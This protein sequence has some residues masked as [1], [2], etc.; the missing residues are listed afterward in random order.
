MIC[1]ALTSLR[2]TIHE[3]EFLHDKAEI[4]SFFEKLSS[5]QTFLE[6]ESSAMT[7]DLKTK[8]IDFALKAEDLQIQLS[9]F[10]QSKHTTSSQEKASK[11][12]LHQDLQEATEN[13]TELL[14]IITKGKEYHESAR[15]MASDTLTIFMKKFDYYFLQSNPVVFLDDEAAKIS[16]F[17]KLSSMQALLQEESSAGGAI[18]ND[19]KTEIIN[20]VLKAEDDIDTQ[21]NNLLEAED[22]EDYQQKA[23]QLNQTLQGA[24]ENAEGFLMI[25]NSKKECDDEIEEMACDALSSLME[26]IQQGFHDDETVIKSLLEK[27]SSLQAF[28][29][30]KS[31]GGGGVTDLEAKIKNFAIKAGDDIKIQINNFLQ[32]KHTEH[33]EEASQQLRQTLQEAAEITAELLG[34]IYIEEQ[35]EKEREST[36]ASLTFLMSI[37]NNYE[38]AF[39]KPGIKLDLLVK[40]SSLKNYLLFKKSSGCATIND[41]ETK[42]EIFALK[43]LKDLM[44]IEHTQL[45]R[46]LQEV[47]EN[48]NELL[49]S[50]K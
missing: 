29:K 40:L 9:N 46:T 36:C 3:V 6:E 49:M 27:I 31:S 48:A 24:T 32:A 10:F 2:G 43:A 22:T 34:N 17:E 1:N 23:S 41:F 50:G 8:I 19:L 39:D 45:N 44:M 37:V 4:K 25:I 13:A 14:K 38:F 16:F 21:V 28:L 30:K 11:G 12:L 20:F 42:I 47:T 18:I 5:L 26:T 33:E 7:K 35:H 15:E